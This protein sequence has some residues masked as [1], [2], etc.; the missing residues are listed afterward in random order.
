MPYV[1]VPKGCSANI[2]IWLRDWFA[3]GSACQE[4][5]L[6][7]VKT[8]QPVAKFKTWTNQSSKI[9]KLHLLRKGTNQTYGEWN[10]DHSTV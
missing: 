8:K 2:M 4:Q 5:G 1:P 10:T 7:E 6:V 9:L 3:K